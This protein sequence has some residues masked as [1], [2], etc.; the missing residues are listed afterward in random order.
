[1]KDEPHGLAAL[2]LGMCISDDAPMT[3]ASFEVNKNIHPMIFDGGMEGST[4][5]GKFT[6]NCG[7]SPNE[8]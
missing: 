4:R 8:C 3:A 2:G 5:C 7:L 6:G 1:M